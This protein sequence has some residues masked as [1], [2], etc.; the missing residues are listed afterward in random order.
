MSGL[1][2]LGVGVGV[3]VAVLASPLWF[4]SH[5]AKH[6]PSTSSISSEST[7]YSPV[8]KVQGWVSGAAVSWEVHLPELS[9]RPFGFF[10]FGT[11]LPLP[12]LRESGRLFRGEGIGAGGEL[13]GV[14]AVLEQT[15]PRLVV[16]WWRGYF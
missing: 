10:L 13:G 6:S 15:R 2:A 4:T 1:G 16:W 7:T 8:C 5:R 11:P 12:L 9:I 3:G 14:T